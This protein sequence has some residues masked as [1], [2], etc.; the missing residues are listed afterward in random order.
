M[1]LIEVIIAITIG[2]LT[3]GGLLMS[4]FMAAQ[5]SLIASQ[6]SAAMQLCIQT[7]EEMRASDYEDIDSEHFPSQEG[8]ELTTADRSGNAVLCEE[9]IKISDDSSENIEAKRIK[10]DVNWRYRKL[11]NS[12]PYET[13]IYKFH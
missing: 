1:T 5:G 13:I 8:I 6:H 4:L 11:D 9:K 10:I 12:V 3:T 2:A 7:I